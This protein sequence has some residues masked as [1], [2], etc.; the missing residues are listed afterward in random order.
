MAEYF[1]GLVA[2]LENSQQL[3]RSAEGVF[4]QMAWGAGGTLIG[5]ILLG[6]LG[7]LIGSVSGSLIGYWKS[8]DYQALIG[9]LKK[10]DSSK[11]EK[12]AKSVKKLV[13]SPDVEKLR[14]FIT[15]DAQRKDLLKLLVNELR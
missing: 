5:A 7:A 8:D 6:P 2:I 9:V 4:K 3:K 15:E 14:R 1:G 10:L 11:Q 13:G 12:I